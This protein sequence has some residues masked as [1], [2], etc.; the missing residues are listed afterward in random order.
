M[1]ALYVEDWGS[2]RG[3]PQVLH[4]VSGQAQEVADYARE[5]VCRRA[6]LEP[7]PLCVLRPLAVGLGRAAEGF[8]ELGRL[9]VE[10]LG[11]LAAATA[12]AADR[13]E[14]ADAGAAALGE[15]LRRE[16]A[17]LGAGTGAGTG[18]AA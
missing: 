1:N 7:S 18:E 14:E 8:E 12:A 13:L 4:E 10:E 9:L 6:G 3:V 11:A 5:H 17:D 15:R 2:L 16:L